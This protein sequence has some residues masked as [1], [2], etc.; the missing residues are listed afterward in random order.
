FLAVV[1]EFRRGEIDVVSLPGERRKAHVHIRFGLAVDPAAF[2]V[3][4]FQTERIEYLDLVAVLQIHAA[5]RPLLAAR[6]RLEWKQKFKMGLKVRKALFA[7]A[8]G[9]QQVALVDV[10][11]G[12]G[13]SA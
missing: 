1:V 12:P 5:V 2:V 6:V 9:L 8:A 3:L 10:R 4:T 13:I 11:A 7:F